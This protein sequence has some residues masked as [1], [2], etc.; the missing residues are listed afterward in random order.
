MLARLE[1]VTVDCPDVPVSST[2]VSLPLGVVTVTKTAAIL[3]PK[4]EPNVATLL[5]QLTTVIVTELFTKV[6][7]VG[8]SSSLVLDVACNGIISEAW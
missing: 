8:R 3:A 7:P 2:L 4:L 1:R 5:F 6:E